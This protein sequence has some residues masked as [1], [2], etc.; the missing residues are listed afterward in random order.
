MNEDA[1]LEIVRSGYERFGN[2]D[3]EGLLNL[4]SDDIDWSTP[5]LEHAPY[6]GRLLGLEEVGEF[7]EKLGETEDFAYFEPTEFIAQGDRVVVL[8]RSKATVKATER[9]YE[10][11]WVHIF[12]IHE[13]KIT[14]FAEFFDSALVDKAFQKAASA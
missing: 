3:I 11:D 7:F 5:H 10:M 13:G 9:S 14:N 6:G 2:G 1:N 4:F 12:T 8:G